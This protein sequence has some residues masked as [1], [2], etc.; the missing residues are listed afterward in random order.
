MQGSRAQAPPRATR[1]QTPSW[2]RQRAAR[3]TTSSRK[4]TNKRQAAIS[5]RFSYL[6]LSRPPR[7]ARTEKKMTILSVHPPSTV[8][9]H[10][11]PSLAWP[12]PAH[13]KLISRCQHTHTTTARRPFNTLAPSLPRSTA[14]SSAASRL[15]SSTPSAP[16]LTPQLFSLIIATRAAVGRLPPRRATCV[17]GDKVASF[18]QDPELLHPELPPPRLLDRVLLVLRPLLYPMFVCMVHLHQSPDLC[19][20]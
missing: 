4:H 15:C 13:P 2:T 12:A 5:P 11:P 3:H 20:A 18:G 1:P 9:R 8:H 19:P 6:W 14:A 10:H 17:F 7:V 16:H